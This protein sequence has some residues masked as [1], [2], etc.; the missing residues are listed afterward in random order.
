MAASTPLEEVG[1]HFA[2][3]R[4]RI[5]Q[6]EA[7]ALRKL[8]HPSRSRRL[9]AVLDIALAALLDDWAG[10]TAIPDYGEETRALYLGGVVD[11][12][13]AS[14]HR[15]V[16]TSSASTNDNG[17]TRSSIP[18]GPDLS[19]LNV[20]LETLSPRE[21][22]VIKMRLGL[23]DHGVHT[24]AEIG[25]HFA[26]AEDRIQQ[27]YAKARRKLRR[28]IRESLETLDLRPFTTGCNAE[29]VGIENPLKS[30]DAE[31]HTS[32]GE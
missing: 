7:K 27:I 1:Q 3:T 5:L 9:R 11:S 16:P 31:A 12:E 30:V 21:E 32:S 2:V 15:D 25:Q 23:E 18:K 17:E 26:V 20:A 22:K 8:R 29:E 19:W 4:E 24:Y 28:H 13:Q 6:I 14:E 10:V